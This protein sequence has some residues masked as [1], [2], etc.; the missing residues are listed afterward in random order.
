M[1]KIKS[2]ETTNVMNPENVQ[3]MF[4]CWLQ[5]SRKMQKSMTL[6]EWELQG[7]LLDNVV[8]RVVKEEAWKGLCKAIEAV[9]EEGNRRKNEDD[10]PLQ[11]TY[12]APDELTSG[13]IRIWR[14]TDPKAVINIPVIDWRGEAEVVDGG[15]NTRSTGQE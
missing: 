12:H 3:G 7:W 1:L 6:Q 9:M 11:M 8:H 4:L 13:C 15:A 2:M 14:Q 5:V 10:S